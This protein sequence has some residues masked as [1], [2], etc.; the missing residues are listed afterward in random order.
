MLDMFFRSI[1]RTVITDSTGSLKVTS[2]S[3]ETEVIVGIESDN[4][5]MLKQNVSTPNPLTKLS[6]ACFY[7]FKRQERYSLCVSLPG[8]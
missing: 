7:C 6:F 1:L 4:L 2:F 5:R 3:P 8:K